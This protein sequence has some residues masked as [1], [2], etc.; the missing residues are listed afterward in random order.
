MKLG[1]M[2]N[3]ANDIYKEITF[4]G[5]NKFDF[6]D[7]TIEPPRAQPC[8]INPTKVLSLCRKY[9]LAI[10]GHTNFYLPWASAVVRLKEA[11]MQ[12]LT[13]HLQIFSLLNV[14]FVA[15]HPHWNQPNC[16]PDE[17]VKRMIESLN[18][19]VSVAHRNNM[20]IMLENLM[21][22]FLN[23]PK[24]FEPIFRKVHNLR[25]LLDCGHAQRT[26]KLHNLTGEYLTRYVEKLVHVHA[27]DNTG[28]HDDHLP[29]GGGIIDWKNIVRQLKTHYYDGTITLEVWGKDRRQILHSRDEFYKIWHNVI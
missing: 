7:L 18:I 15:I 16:Q 19:L 4:I 22:G 29:I 3:P 25:F 23:T 13:E 11:S 20:H 27:S 9:N 14:Q 28:E 21:S 24:S 1:M 6:I 8:D 2:N 5:E 10:I 26:G 12:E 17:I